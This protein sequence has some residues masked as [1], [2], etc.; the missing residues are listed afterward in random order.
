MYIFIY[1]FIYFKMHVLKLYYFYVI[2]LCIHKLL[3][4]KNVDYQFK[5][6]ITQS[7]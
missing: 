5:I 1:L 7:H 6:Q 3:F 4:L 2:C